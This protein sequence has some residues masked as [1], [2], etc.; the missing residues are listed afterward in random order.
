M[1]RSGMVSRDSHSIE[2]AYFPPI[3]YCFQ[4][5]EFKVFSPL[6]LHRITKWGVVAFLA[7]GCSILDSNPVFIVDQVSQPVE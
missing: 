7:P 4:S 6:E 2:N 3:L 5:T 1:D